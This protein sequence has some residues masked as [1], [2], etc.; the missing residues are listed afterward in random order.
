MELL[1]F[2]EAKIPIFEQLTD[3]LPRRSGDHNRI[4]LG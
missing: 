1:D 3:K 2:E 4:R